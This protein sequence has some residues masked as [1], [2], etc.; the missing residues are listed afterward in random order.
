MSTIIGP[1]EQQRREKILFFRTI[2]SILS[3]IPRRVPIAPTDVSERLPKSNHKTVKVCDT[4]AQVL[5]MEHEILAV[6]SSL[7]FTIGPDETL[8]IVA[9]SANDV[10]NVSESEEDTP[11]WPIRFLLAINPMAA[12]R[13]AK[14]TIVLPTFVKASPPTGLEKAQVL[15]YMGEVGKTK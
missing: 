12:F 1:E 2:S 15:E 13:H 3:E 8:R 5:V 10:A 6:S 14:K 11:S 9:V 7:N 4:L